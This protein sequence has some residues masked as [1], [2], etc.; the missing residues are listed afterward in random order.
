MGFFGGGGSDVEPIQI[1]ATPE[2]VEINA[3][4]LARRRAAVQ[5]R[6]RA[7]ASLRVDDPPE[8]ASTPEGTGLRIG[9][10]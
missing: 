4:E 9:G 2:P 3:G 6:R 5:R 8:I 1:A 7:V 10:T